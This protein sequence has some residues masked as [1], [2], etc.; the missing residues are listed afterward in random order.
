MYVDIVDCDGS[1]TPRSTRCL[2]ALNR[3]DLPR[4]LRL[5]LMTVPKDAEHEYRFYMWHR[6]EDHMRKYMPRMPTSDG[7][8]NAEL[9]EVSYTRMFE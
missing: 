3:T 9:H 6:E 2:P 5:P 4:A 8:V 7:S 1:Q